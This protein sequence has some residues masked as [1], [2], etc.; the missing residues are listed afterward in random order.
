MTTH[1]STIQPYSAALPIRLIRTD[2]GTQS[3]VMIDWTTVAD[4]AEFLA[5]GTQLP[6][7]IVFH[8]GA[9]Y[10]LADGFH[11][12]HAYMQLGLAE[13]DAEV[14]SGSVRDARLYSAGSNTSH[15]LRRTNEDKRNAVLMLLN[16]EEWYKRSD[17]WIAHH[18]GVSQPFVSSLRADS[19][20]NAYKMGDRVVQRGDQTYTISTAN[21][22]R[23]SDQDE[24]AGPGM[25]DE[26][27]APLARVLGPVL[28]TANEHKQAEVVQMWREDA[29]NWRRLQADQQARRTEPIQPANFSS[30]SNEWYTPAEYVNAARKLMGGIDLDPASN[31]LANETIG[32]TTYYTEADNGLAQTWRGRVF[33]NPPYGTTAGE[34]NAGVWAR[35][36]A[37]EYRAGNVSEAVLLVNANTERKWFSQLWAF[38]ICFTDH[39]IQFYTPDGVGAQPVDG[40]AL[41]YL[42]PNLSDFVSIFTAFGDVAV[43]LSRGVYCV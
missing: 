6:P 12:Y 30:A 17:N 14:R 4:Y 24:P 25:F 29:E 41:V 3:R 27:P 42:G 32:A 10:W 35:K 26:E 38:P 20:Y 15:G 11:R 9:E 2:G 28:S 23:L 36:L 22:G 16:D 13:V 40:N 5:V 34:S 43:S 31:Q 1:D 33:L 8:D 37:A 7:V 18:C 21:I 19:S 39:R